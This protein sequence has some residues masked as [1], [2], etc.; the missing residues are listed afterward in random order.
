MCAHITCAANFSRGSPKCLETLRPVTG[1]ESQVIHLHV[2][3]TVLCGACLVRV[4][5]EVVAVRGKEV[6]LRDDFFATEF[7][8]PCLSTDAA[9]LHHLISTTHVG[10]VLGH[11]AAERVR[12]AMRTRQR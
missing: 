5:G 10:A 3:V 11:C 9:V 1:A 8:E 12:L 2:L 4:D 6:S 7:S